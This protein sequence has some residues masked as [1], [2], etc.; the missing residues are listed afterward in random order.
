[1]YMYRIMY[2]LQKKLKCTTCISK[3]NMTNSFV[4]TVLFKRITTYLKGKII[5]A[6][7]YEVDTYTLTKEWYKDYH[8]EIFMLGITMKKKKQDP[9][10]KSN[11]SF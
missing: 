1:M 6:L 10:K 2:N 11:K 9:D 3:I 5:P 7:I 4:K 8:M